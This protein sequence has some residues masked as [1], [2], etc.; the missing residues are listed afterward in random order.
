MFDYEGRDSLE[1][2]PYPFDFPLPYGHINTGYIVHT[3]SANGLSACCF[4]VK[5]EKE[6]T[7]YLGGR[8]RKIE[9]K[10]TCLERERASTLEG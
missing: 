6:K 4:F 7:T 9:S 5:E 2:P 8:E 10:R 3:I 1:S